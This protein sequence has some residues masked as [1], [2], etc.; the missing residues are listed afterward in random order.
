MIKTKILFT[1][2]WFF[3][4]LFIQENFHCFCVLSSWRQS[5]AG[6]RR[7]RRGRSPPRDE[8]A[9][10][11]VPGVPVGTRSGWACG[12][13]AHQGRGDAWQGTARGGGDE[14]PEAWGG[15]TRVARG[16]SRVAGGGR[17]DT[18]E[19]NARHPEPRRAVKSPKTQR[20]PQPSLGDGHPQP[21]PPGG[22]LSPHTSPNVCPHWANW[23]LAPPQLLLVAG[24]AKLSSPCSKRN[25]PHVP[26]TCLGGPD[27]VFG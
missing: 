11:P 3:F 20:S 7:Q 12:T 16:G 6:R 10:T 18:L 14:H 21:S 5:R 27:A 17:G 15:S 4:F 1:C 23:L 2:V 8:A 22:R 24:R 13:G 25:P 26:S 19:D 9:R